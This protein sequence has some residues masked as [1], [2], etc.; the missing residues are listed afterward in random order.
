MP[1][2]EELERLPSECWSSGRV[3]ISPI[4][5]ENDMIYATYDCELTEEQKDIVNPAWFS[6]GRAYLNRDD[7]YP[8]LIRSER[9]EPIGFINLY[10]WIGDE[11]AYSWSYYIDKNSQGK[12]YG[13]QAA[14]LA[15]SIL[16]SA[17]PQVPIKLATEER[18]VKAQ[19][20]YKSLGFTRLDEL[21]GD[22]LVFGLRN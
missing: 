14:R 7:N 18:N 4:L 11:S 10:V 19:A 12:G 17:N 3:S 15:I 1:L 16:K 5:T 21:D 20:L 22:D 8:C 9:G 13:K 2:R 6:I